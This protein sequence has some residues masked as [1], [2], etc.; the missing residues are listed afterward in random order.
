[1][2]VFDVSQTKDLDNYTVLNEPISE[3]ALM[4]RASFQ[5]TKRLIREISPQKRILVFAG[6][7][8][9]GGDARW[10]YHFLI[11][12]G[13][14]TTLFGNFDEDFSFPEI[15]SSDI[16]IDGLFGVGINRPL[17]GYYAN[18]IRYLNK[19]KA[20]IYAIDIPSGLFGEDNSGN[21]QETII[22]ARKTFTFQYPKLSFF[23][24]EN[25]RYVGEW[26]TIEIGLHPDVIEQ[27]PVSYYFTK[28][29][30]IQVMRKK[31][32][33]FDHKGKFG[34]ALIFAGSKGKFGAAVLASRACLRSGV[35]L[36]TVHVPTDAEY[37][38]QTTLPEAMIE[39][40]KNR[41]FITEGIEPD[42]YTAIGVG[43]GLGTDKKTERFLH[44]LLD[45]KKNIVLDADAL[46]LIAENKELLRKIPH[47]SI[48]TP[49]PKEFDRLI[50]LSIDSFERLQKARGLASKLQSYIVLKGAYTAVC[51][52]DKNVYF[53]STGNPG[54]ATAGSGDVLTGIITGLLAQAYSPK[55]ASLI[56]VYIHGLAGD[57]AAIENSE[58]SLIAG[59]I[60]DYLGKALQSF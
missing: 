24:A 12:K 48:L 23:F 22:R 52:P 6:P 21:N 31:R 1:M 9:N 2:K 17:T 20:D 14:Q 44:D 40:D 8:N 46:N 56:G 3:E 30:E 42:R 55:E 58:E 7:G 51:C 29:K 53:N 38:L 41:K 59:D 54:M 10:V 15:H 43:P 37:I 49:H 28:S 32:N 60:I 18:L 33:K 34:H 4:Q 27:T 36:L 16:V 39:L 35:G 26:E 57:I 50:G 45:K 5:F 13:Y 47:G 19:S 25:E 11:E